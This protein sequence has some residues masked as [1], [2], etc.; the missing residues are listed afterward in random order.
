MVLH[1][2]FNNIKT[3]SFVLASPRHKTKLRFAIGNSRDLYL[4]FTKEFGTSWK[5]N[6]FVLGGIHDFV[7]L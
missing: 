1:L 7:G 4:Q 2:R 6:S 5:M 3:T